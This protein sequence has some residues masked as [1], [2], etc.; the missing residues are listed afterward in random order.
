VSGST[1]G[2]ILL[3]DPYHPYAIRFLELAAAKGMRAVCI[4]TDAADI[5]RNVRKFPALSGP[6]VSAASV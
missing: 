5:V 2:E 4:Y 3:Q 1:A 6:Q